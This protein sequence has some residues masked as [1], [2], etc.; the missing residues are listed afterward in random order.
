[1]SPSISPCSSIEFFTLHEQLIP[2]NPGFT[3][4]E[5]SCPSAFGP[6]STPTTG[7]SG[8]I[9]AGVDP[10]MASIEMTMKPVYGSKGL[11][12]LAWD[13]RWY[14]AGV[15]AWIHLPRHALL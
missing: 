11:R 6:I 5:S 14:D 1:M 10:L 13:E 12:G 3:V 7:P 2:G 8:R 9:R 15:V 4:V